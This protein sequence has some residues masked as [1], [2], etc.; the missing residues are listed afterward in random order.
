M[1]KNQRLG[2]EQGYKF[3]RENPS[4]DKVDRKEKFIVELEVKSK[5]NQIQRNENNKKKK[6]ELER[7]R[8]QQEVLN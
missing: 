2:F 6:E 3:A 8:L 1:D 7:M 5:L 4:P